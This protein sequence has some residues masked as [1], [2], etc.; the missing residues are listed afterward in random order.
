MIIL[1]TYSSLDEPRAK[2]TA[3]PLLQIYA[4]GD[5]NSGEQITLVPI[6]QAAA[7]ELVTDRISCVSVQQN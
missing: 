1:R 4:S 3:L 2:S 5:D 7:E 6:D